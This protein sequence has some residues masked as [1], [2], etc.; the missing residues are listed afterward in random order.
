M[1]EEP[2][3]TCVRQPISCRV[4]QHH[5]LGLVSACIR[6]YFRDEWSRIF[7]RQDQSCSAP[8]GKPLF[9][10][11]LVYPG[12]PSSGGP[13]VVRYRSGHKNFVASLIANRGSVLGLFDRSTNMVQP[14]GSAGFEC[15][16]VDLQHE[17]GE[18]RDGNIVRIGAD[19]RTWLRTVVPAFSQQYGYKNAS[20][21]SAKTTVPWPTLLWLATKSRCPPCLS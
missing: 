19:I 16:C 10:A 21:L 5:G 15:I 20:S 6:G 7:W 13:P 14:W 18:H 8:D 17:P 1:A 2:L 9:L 4:T 12:K 11:L 3:Q